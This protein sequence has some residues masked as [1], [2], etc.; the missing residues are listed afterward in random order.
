MKETKPNQ[1]ISLLLFFHKVH[2]ENINGL[3]GRIRISHKLCTT[4]LMSRDQMG[5]S[6]IK[7]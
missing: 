4:I 1:T 3:Y 2:N 7:F 6:N 5:N